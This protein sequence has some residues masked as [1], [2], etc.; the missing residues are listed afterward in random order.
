LILGEERIASIYREVL[1]AVTLKRSAFSAAEQP[2]RDALEAVQDR[3]VAAGD[4]VH[5]N[6][7]F[8]HASLGAE[9]FNASLD[10]KASGPSRVYFGIA[11]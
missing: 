8:E 7:A 11:P 5:G 9:Q 3:T 6:I 2:T 4:F 10:V 1:R